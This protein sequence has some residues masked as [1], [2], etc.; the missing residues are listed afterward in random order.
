MIVLDTHAWLWWAAE[1]ARLSARARRAMVRAPALGVSIVSC[2]E[3]AMLAHRGR[4]RSDSHLLEWQEKALALEKIELLPMTPAIAIRAA[5]L[6]A[7]RGGDPADWI[8]VATAQEMQV[9]LVTKDERLRE[10]GVVEVVW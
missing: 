1:P 4:V 10:A 9:K 5:G 3:A 8:I 7:T 6:Q 2:W